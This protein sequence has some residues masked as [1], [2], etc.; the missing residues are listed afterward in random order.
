MS[1]QQSPCEDSQA[2]ASCR[3]Q[4]PRSWERATDKAGTSVSPKDGGK[5]CRESPERTA[6]PVGRRGAYVA[7]GPGLEEPRSRVEELGSP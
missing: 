7:A 1:L 3:M 5:G 2:Q 4:R 6:G